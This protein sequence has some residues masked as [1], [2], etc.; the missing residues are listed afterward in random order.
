MKKGIGMLLVLLLTVVWVSGCD[1]VGENEP[2]STE[3]LERIHANVKNLPPAPEAL[4]K[5]YTDST[6]YMMSSTDSS[7]EGGG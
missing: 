5:A 2:E 3:V 7:E 4:L 1:L 6:R